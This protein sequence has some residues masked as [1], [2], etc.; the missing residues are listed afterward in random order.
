M[1][2]DGAANQK[3][4]GIGIMIISLKGITLEKSLR[5]GF[6]VTNNEVEY[7]ALQAGLI[8]VHKLGGKFV[9]AYCDSRLIAGQVW[10][11]FEA[12][13]QRMLWYLGQVKHLSD[14]FRSFTLEQ[15]S[16]S[17]NSHTNSLTT[18]A[19]T[20]RE[21]ILRIILEEDLAIPAY[22]TQI[23]VGVHFMRVGPSWMDPIVSF[24]KDGT[25]PDDR[26]EAKKIHRK[27]LRFSL[28]EDQNLYKRSYSRPYLLCI[29]LKAVEVLLEELHKVIYASHMG[30]KSLIHR[31]LTQGY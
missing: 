6:S 31:A 20:I 5:L 22:D 12:K 29:H 17:R 16:R 26:I 25:L 10:G 30:G 8:V 13:D 28:S 23:L 4:L 1:F 9:T 15:T 2:V 11:D 7:E 14:S 3:G 27:A 19:T 24:L 18:L 21:K